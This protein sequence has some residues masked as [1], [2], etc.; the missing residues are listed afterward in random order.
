MLWRIQTSTAHPRTHCRFAAPH[1]RE[2]PRPASLLP[3]APGTRDA[4]VAVVSVGVEDPIV[5]FRVSAVQPLFPPGVRG[6]LLDELADPRRLEAIVGQALL[7]V[8]DR[9]LL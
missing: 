4:Q 1:L 7:E 2:C 9:H 6:K 5:V 8:I 3:G